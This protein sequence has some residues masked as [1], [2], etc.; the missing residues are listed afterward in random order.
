MNTVGICMGASKIKVLKT[1]RNSNDL[2]IIDFKELSHEGSAVKSLD[3]ILAEFELD[4]ETKYAVTGRQSKEFVNFPSIS[5]PEA[6]ELAYK[7]IKDKY[8]AVDAIVSAGGET[9][10]A[11]ELDERGR[12]AD[13]HS[14]NKC[15]SGT[16]EFFLQQLKRMDIKLE[17]AMEIAQLD[18][19][20]HLSGR[21]SVFCKS[22]CTHALNKG[23][24]KGKIVAGLCSMMADKILE[25]LSNFKA[26]SIM[27]IGGSSK[28]KVMIDY[29]EQKLDEVIVPEE[30][31][32]FEALGTALWGEKNGDNLDLN[33]LYNKDKS[34]FEFLPPL[35]NYRDKVS[36][37][38][39]ERGTVSS[40]DKC[41]LGVD[42][43][44]T[45]TKAV[46]MREKDNALLASV[47]LRTNGDPVGAARKCYTKLAEKI[48]ETEIKIMGLGVTGSGRQIVG[49]HA[50]TKSIHNEIMAH[51]KAAVF[52]DSEVETIFEIGGQDA[53]YTYLV[54]EVPTDYAM[55]EACSA[56]TGSFLEEAAEESFNIEVEDIEEIA[57]KGRKPPNFND[58][59]SAFISSDIKSAVQEGL[60]V[61]DICAGLVYS[62]C[63]NYTNRVKGNRAVGDKVFMQGG[64]CYN[65]AVPIAMAALTEKEI[66]VPPE[67]GLMGAYGEA[68]L[69][70]QNLNLAL[71]EEKE[72]KLKELAARK[73]KYHKSFICQGGKE[74]CDRRCEISVM[75]IEGEKYPFGGACNK[76]VN[77]ANDLD[78]DVK[79]LDYVH[80]R[81]KMVYEKY[82][83]EPD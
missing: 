12:I 9:F 59:C 33:N 37:K 71:T 72:F 30:A 80:Q 82:F 81:E 19:P 53:K 25:L 20:Y 49:L 45:T 29:L 2:K 68:L 47:Y 1:K 16:G 24:D 22:D 73:I 78:Y 42:V 36:F 41:I 70:K 13:V 75:E 11:Y 3:K 69:V 48:G 43:G 58:Q 66:I 21:C 65:K 32:Y 4:A 62:I 83:A 67:P 14:G 5:E 40:G 27:V 15:A 76:Y 44:S 38:N 64:V 52:F 39:M 60:D 63:L 23:E 31:N 51:A 6:T 46:I 54:N 79:N 50:L 61:E 18:N 17:E 35:E 7:Y 34:S 28:N 56:G 55:N 57:L 77:L 8:P 74:D 10:M 26:K